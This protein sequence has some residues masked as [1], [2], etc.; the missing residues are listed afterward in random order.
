MYRHGTKLYHQRPRLTSYNE[1]YFLRIVRNHFEASLIWPYRKD[2]GQKV[3]IRCSVALLGVLYRP[4]APEGY[5]PQIQ[6]KG[7]GGE[8]G[9]LSL[10]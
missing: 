7:G 3:L 8:N 5:E 6:E 10:F 4:E 1:V 2:T 9:Q